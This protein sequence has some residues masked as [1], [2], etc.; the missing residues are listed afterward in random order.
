MNTAIVPRRCPLSG[1]C[2]PSPLLRIKLRTGK[3]GD[4]LFRLRHVVGVSINILRI[5][6]DSCRS[7]E[8]SAGLVFA[9]P[10]LFHSPLY[11]L[12]FLPTDG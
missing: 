4:N 10:V 12:D 5:L 6:P 9:I 7:R 8:E 11:L 1:R 3:A 2:H